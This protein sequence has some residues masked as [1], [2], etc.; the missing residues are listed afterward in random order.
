MFRGQIRSVS[1]AR[2]ERVSRREDPFPVEETGPLPLRQYGS[3]PV[4]RDSVGFQ[5]NTCRADDWPDPPA[6]SAAGPMV[7]RMIAVKK[8]AGLG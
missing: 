7:V 2:S 8:C 4:W 3:A 1:V 5:G 6:L